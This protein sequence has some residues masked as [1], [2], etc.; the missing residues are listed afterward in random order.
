MAHL[1][2]LMLGFL[3]CMTKIDF[4]VNRLARLASKSD[5]IL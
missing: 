4:D 2:D 1:P 3:L 5:K